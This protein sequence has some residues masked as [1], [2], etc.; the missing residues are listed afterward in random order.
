M[1]IIIPSLP[2]VFRSNLLL[3]SSRGNCNYASLVIWHNMHVTGKGN[4]LNYCK[5][6]LYL[7]VSLKF[8]QDMASILQ[9][10]SCLVMHLWNS[11]I[12][13]FMIKM[14]LSWNHSDLKKILWWD[15]MNSP[16][17]LNVPSAKN[18]PVAKHTD[19]FS[20]IAENALCSMFCCPR[21][22]ASVLRGYWTVE[23]WGRLTFSTALLQTNANS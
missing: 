13:C 16:V 11:F 3:S 10:L 5:M 2:D 7:R 22:S 4:M 8:Y 17:V 23:G 15:L 6:W 9:C 1:T 12:L 19:I 20:D 21:R 14:K 18:H